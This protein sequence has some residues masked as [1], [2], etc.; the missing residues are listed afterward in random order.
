MFQ[1]PFD[2]HVYIERLASTVEGGGNR[3][4][5]DPIKLSKKFENTIC[6]LVALDEKMQGRINKLEELC[7]REQEEHKQRAVDLES[8][9]KVC[10]CRF[11][12]SLR[13]P[14]HQFEA[15]MEYH[16]YLHFA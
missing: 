1:E 10:D 4:S 15:K 9:Y 13:S 5:F 12:L 11:P 8:T 3:G 16:F 2:S 6:E 7:I 14:Q